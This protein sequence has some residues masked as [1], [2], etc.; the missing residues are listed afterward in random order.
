MMAKCQLCPWE[1]AFPCFE[2]NSTK[3]LARLMVTA[4]FLEHV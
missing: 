2:L 1:A 3:A 4:A